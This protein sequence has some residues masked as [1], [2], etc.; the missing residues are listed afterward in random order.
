MFK[1]P[2]NLNSFKSLNQERRH[3]LQRESVTCSSGWFLLTVF[4]PDA[5]C[6]HENVSYFPYCVL[7]L[8]SVNMNNWCCWK[9]SPDLCMYWAQWLKLPA[10]V[11]CEARSLY[12]L[13]RVMRHLIYPT[14]QYQDYQDYQVTLSTDKLHS[15]CLFCQAKWSKTVMCWS[16]LRRWIRWYF[17][18]SI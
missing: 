18:S 16:N 4:V 1:S 10:P 8:M 17:S 5:W 11:R 3:I 13:G 15:G 12:C 9:V 7:S 2:V 6:R 14:F